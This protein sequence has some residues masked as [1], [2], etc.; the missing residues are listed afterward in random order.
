ML[1]TEDSDKDGVPDI[2]D[3][4]PFTPSE[5]KTDE[6]GCPLDSDG[7]G[8]ADYKD[9]EPNS[10]Q[11]AYVNEEGVALT[12]EM[13]M[14]HYME[15]I[16]STSAT[17]NTVTTYEKSPQERIKEVH[18]IMN[19]TQDWYNPEMLHQQ[20]PSGFEFMDKNHNQQVDLQEIKDEITV[21]VKS[22]KIEETSY[23]ELFIRYF[24]AAP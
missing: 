17:K 1:I 21:I 19:Q 6:K 11:G 5:A 18:T 3:E 13:L 4:C 20:Y 8:I 7:D 14:K 15:F 12:D 2:D 16:D 24:L 10:P 23:L 9:K 22:R